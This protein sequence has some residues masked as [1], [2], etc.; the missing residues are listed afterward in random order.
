MPEDN[1]KQY[2]CLS[3]GEPIDNPSEDGRLICENCELE[4]FL[5]N[6]RNDSRSRDKENN[7]EKEEDKDNKEKSDSESNQDSEY[8][9]KDAG[10]NQSKKSIEEDE[11]KQNKKSEK[12]SSE[13]NAVAD[14]SS[15]AVDEKNKGKQKSKN[16]TQ[17]TQSPA[18]EAG[19][20]KKGSDTSPTITPRKN[21]KQQA[22]DKKNKTLPPKNNLSEKA[23]NK[24]PPG[25]IADSAKDKTKGKVPGIAGKALGTA[26]AAK[27]IKDKGIKGAGKEVAKEAAKKAAKEAIKKSAAKIAAKLGVQVGLKA[28][29][30]N[31]YFWAVVGIVFLIIIVLFM[32]M[33]L[34]IAIMQG[35]GEHAAKDMDNPWYTFISAITPGEYWSSPWFTSGGY[36]EWVSY[37]QVGGLSPDGVNIIAAMP[38]RTR[39]LRDV[40]GQFIANAIIPKNSA[41][42]DNNKE[43]YVICQPGVE[44]HLATEEGKYNPWAEGAYS[45]FPALA[46]SDSGY[47]TT[48]YMTSPGGI[49]GESRG[50]KV[51]EAQ[52][53]AAGSPK[54][55][56][57]GGAHRLNNEEEK[58]YLNMRWPY[59]SNWP[60][61]GGT[62][63]IV[64][65]SS[66]YFGKKVVI[67]N[68]GTGRMAIGIVGEWGP[69]KNLGTPSGN[70]MVGMSPDLMYYLTDGNPG[71]NQTNVEVA[72]AVDQS[73]PPGPF[74][75]GDPSMAMGTLSFNG[76]P[77]PG[78]KELAIKIFNAYATEYP[79]LSQ[80]RKKA[81]SVALSQIGYPYY[82]GGVYPP[83][84]GADCSGF[85]IF[86]W[87][88]ALGSPI[89]KDG[90][91]AFKPSGVRTADAI[92]SNA[93]YHFKDPSKALPG[94]LMYRKKHIMIFAG[95]VDGTYYFVHSGDSVSLP[96]GEPQYPARPINS[97]G[98]LT[99]SAICIKELSKAGPYT[100]ARYNEFD[101]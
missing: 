100:F 39:D 32:I 29:L 85:T 78:Q 5:E 66:D 82:W 6:S 84:R 20:I 89:T 53:I 38:E 68:T 23:T 87:N 26:S 21:L 19:G 76:N 71:D 74:V 34:S 56:F 54:V 59:V 28:L 13:D 33:G 72:F 62:G 73:L 97:D 57:P 31:P 44:L 75:I 88:T 18:S 94:D 60:Y 45:E 51:T 7:K 98:F 95:K 86:S 43:D 4:E 11:E 93:D 22:A 37:D 61:N 67:V 25:K 3:C 14:K 16:K 52:W 42:P 46:N 10:K 35:I 24:I 101:F 36:K 55:L 69:G 58:Y 40:D 70:R 2:I 65:E 81:M 80:N 8:N 77:H 9:N 30:S 27:D 12:K 47:R 17:S 15:T 99:S 41:V 91:V 92:G 63:E 1:E 96:G 49:A 50:Q 79:G 83:G 90:Y 48:E 64:G